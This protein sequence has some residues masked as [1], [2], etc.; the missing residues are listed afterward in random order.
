MIVAYNDFRKEKILLGD[1]WHDVVL[2]NQGA[3]HKIRQAIANC[4]WTCCSVM[5]EHMEQVYKDAKT[6]EPFGAV[7]DYYYHDRE[8]V[9]SERGAFYEITREG[10]IKRFD[11]MVLLLA[12]GLPDELCEPFYFFLHGW[13]ADKRI[14]PLPYEPHG[15]NV[16]YDYD[17]ESFYV[18]E[19]DWEIQHL[20]RNVDVPEEGLW[21]GD[22]LGL[23][24]EELAAEI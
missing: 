13:W 11:T 3:G 7:A 18:S 2:V 20:C 22:I 6:I 5:D 23:I 10:E 15:K 17:I 14:Y 19:S 1:T 21:V 24:D 9:E 4:D 8:Y 12:K 16:T